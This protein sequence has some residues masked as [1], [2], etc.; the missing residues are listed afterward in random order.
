EKAAFAAFGSGKG[1]ATDAKKVV[2]EGLSEYFMFSVEGSETIAN[3]WSKRMPAVSADGVAFDIVYRLRS[4]QYGPRP[5]RFFIWR[6]DAEHSLG[7]SPLPD[8]IVRMFREN[9]HDGLSYLG[10]QLL[11]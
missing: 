5:V 8:G 1:G 2:K 11:R 4:Y 6:N 7:E 10:Q 9:G 3:G